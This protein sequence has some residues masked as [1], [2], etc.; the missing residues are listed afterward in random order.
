MM[1]IMGKRNYCFVLSGLILLACIIGYFVNGLQL[2]IQFQGGTIM[3]IEMP[4]GNFSA[5]RAAAIVM[6]AIG[7]KATVQKS[8]TYD[9]KAGT[10]SLNLLVLNIASENPINEAE[11]TSVLNAVKKE[12]NLKDI[13][14]ATVNSVEPFIGNEV[15]VKSLYA[16]FWASILIILYVWFRFRTMHGLSAGVF[17]VL[18]LFHDV[19]VMFA[20]YILLKIPINDSFIAAVLTIIGYSINDTVVIY[21]RIRENTKL[22]RKASIYE[23]VNT[24]VV[25]TLNRSINT[26]VTTLISIL[27]L[28]VFAYIYNIQSIIEFALPMTVGIVS[29]V[30]STIFISSPLYLVWQERKLRKK[31]SH[32]PVKA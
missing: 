9:A 23:L 29:G 6:D 17:A 4:D 26:S 28:L 31:T 27:T 19:M 24:S 21:D 2:D 22:M 30:Y 18:A 14:K 15:K 11:R 32:K 20:V 3:Q 10:T 16:I 25:Q 12:F 1:D 13:P 8:K 7:K 5:D